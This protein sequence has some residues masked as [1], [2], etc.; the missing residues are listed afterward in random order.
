M[1][2]VDGSCKSVCVGGV[3]KARGVYVWQANPNGEPKEPRENP[4]RHERNMQTPHRKAIPQPGIELR[5][6]LL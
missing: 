4:H 2:T 3:I 5:T 1:D 6:L